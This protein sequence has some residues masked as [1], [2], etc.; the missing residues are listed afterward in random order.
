MTLIVVQLFALA[1]A[2]NSTLSV[3]QKARKRKNKKKGTHSWYAVPN[4]TSIMVEQRLLPSAT[5][6]PYFNPKQNRTSIS[7]GKKV[8]SDR[9]KELLR[10]KRR[11]SSRK[12]ATKKFAD[13]ELSNRAKPYENFYENPPIKFQPVENS[14]PKPLLPQPDL[15][16]GLRS[17]TKKMKNNFIN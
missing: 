11:L 4:K 17:K 14:M 3:L 15:S 5:H 6:G 1:A 7:S 10:L 13:R 2:S 9:E 8:F 16:A 12:W